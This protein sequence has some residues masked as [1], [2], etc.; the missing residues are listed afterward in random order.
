MS[1]GEGDRVRIKSDS[2]IDPIFLF[3][4]WLLA[5]TLWVILPMAPQAPPSPVPPLKKPVPAAAALELATRLDDL[6]QQSESLASSLGEAKTTAD[7]AARQEQELAAGKRRLDERVREA[8][9]ELAALAHQRSQLEAATRADAEHQRK[10][11]TQME[12]E[13]ALQVTA[14]EK[15]LREAQADEKRLSAEL[16]SAR[17]PLEIVLPSSEFIPVANIPRKLP[18]LVEV[19]NNRVSPL[20]KDFFEIERPKLFGSGPTLARRKKPGETMEEMI[21]PESALSRCLKSLKPDKYYISFL[22]NADSFAAFRAA[23]A[24]VREKGFEVGWLPSDTSGG[25]I[26]IYPV[27][28][29]K[30]LP[31]PDPKLPRVAPI[32]R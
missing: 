11:E 20:N 6:K 16:K 5:G 25:Q 23:R 8:E 21:K 27:K 29:Y 14:L 7:S 32:L 15:R 24:F 22:L 28:I 19:Y 18:Y 26:Q 9:T 2:L 30:T 1:R 12:A 31:A 10:I 17:S 3:L 13:L 4:Y